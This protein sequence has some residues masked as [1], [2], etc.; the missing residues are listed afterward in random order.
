MSIPVVIATSSRA[1]MDVIDFLLVA[2]LKQ[3]EAQAAILP[4]Q[5]A[6]WSFIVIGIGVALA[7]NTFSSQALGAGRQ[8]EASVYAWQMLY[9]S[10]AFGVVGL[11]L[12]PS[13]PAL[14]TVMGA[15]PKVQEL[16]IIYTQIALLTVAPT[17]MAYGLGWFFVGIHRPYVTMW[18]ALEADV[19]NVIVSYSLMFGKLGMPA[20]GFAGAIWGT[21]VATIYRAIRLWLVFLAPKAARAFDTR[22]TWRPSWKGMIGLFRVGFPGGIQF[23]CE[24]VVWL[25]FVS[26]LIGKKFGTVHLIATNTAWQYMRIAFMPANGVGQALTALVGKSIGA[27]DPHRAIRET[28]IAAV[29]ISIYLGFLSILYGWFGPDLIGFFNADPEVMRIGGYVMIAAAVFQLFDALGTIYLSALRGAGDTFVPSIFF[30]VAMWVVVAGGGWFM[31]EFYPKLG[32][33]G[34]WIAASTLFI[35]AWAFLWWR[36]SSRAWMRIR[37]LGPVKSLADPTNASAKTVEIVGAQP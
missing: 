33:V 6:M 35:L 32:S 15:E 2:L 12:I 30:V 25:V 19:V 24:V 14:V 8:R 20:M 34:P 10:L 29:L 28:R 21:L 36:W 37:L 13:V 11:A 16:E 31:T 1:V 5:I 17:I 3:P 18:S 23:F 26:V 9:M 22:N 7:V 4:S 27:G